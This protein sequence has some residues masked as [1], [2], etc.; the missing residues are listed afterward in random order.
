MFEFG[1]YNAR[2]I[3]LSGVKAVETHFLITSKSFSPTAGE[4]DQEHEDYINPGMYALQL[5]DFLTNRLKSK[6]YQI[7]FRCQEDWGH[8]IEIEHEG[9]FTLAV[10]CANTDEDDAD[11]PEHRVFLEPAQPV[12][13]RFFKKI[14]VQNDVEK[15]AETLKQIFSENAE[16][17]NFEI[18]RL[19]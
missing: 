7:R 17:E 6:G 12:V 18:E 13:R 2:T 11:C 3:P 10:G 8:W 5:G 4:L 19:N 1:F 16:V 9:K 15:L 14:D